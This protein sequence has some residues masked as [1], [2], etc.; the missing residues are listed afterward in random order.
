MNL[1]YKCVLTQGHFIRGN[2]YDIGKFECINP[3]DK[4]KLPPIYLYEAI[5]KNM[6]LLKTNNNGEMFSLENDV[7][8]LIRYDIWRNRQ[9]NKLL[10]G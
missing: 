2:N 7:I 3:Y 10:N 4:K 1:K 8:V 5:Q 6:I 9:I